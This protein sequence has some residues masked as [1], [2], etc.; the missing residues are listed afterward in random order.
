MKIIFYRIIVSNRIDVRGLTS[1]DNTPAPYLYTYIVLY[2][3]DRIQLP[4]H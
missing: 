4:Q 3:A 1:I 2:L